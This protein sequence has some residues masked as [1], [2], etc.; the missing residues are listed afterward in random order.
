MFD[1]EKKLYSEIDIIGPHQYRN[2]E[3]SIPISDKSWQQAE[4]SGL[5]NLV[6]DFKGNETMVV[7]KNGHEFINLCSCSYLGLN[8]HPAILQGAIDAVL[9]EK[10]VHPSMSTLR[11]RLTLKD[12]VEEELSSLF[13][14][15]A[16]Q[17]LSASVGSAG[18]LPL[19]ASGHLA[20]GKPHV[21]IFD[22]FCH[23]SMAYMKPVCADEALTLTCPHDDLNFIEDVCKKYPRV[24]YVT[25]GVYSMGGLPSIKGLLELQDKYGLFL[26]FDDSHSMSIK[27]KNG[28][29]YI[30]SQMGEINERT[31][32]VGSLGKGFG[33]GGGVVMIDP[34][35]NA[36]IIRRHAGPMA[37]SQDMIVPVLGLVMAS[38]KI[39][40]S[41]ELGM[42]QEQ[43]L[44][45]I[46]LFDSLVE[47]P[48]KGNKCPI[49][50]I[51]LGEDEDAIR[52][53]KE[54]FELG[55]YS[56]AVYFPIVPKGGAG[57]RIMLRS[58]IARE[59]I[60]RF[61]T[62]LKDIVKKIK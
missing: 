5:I 4:D 14:V 1:N 45:N 13:N 37:W 34:K 53:A 47:T 8:S 42:L 20:G 11:I 60:I 23:F 21:M 10:V 26:F 56:S 58:N 55:F 18:T 7:E 41:P 29:G 62:H 50:L 46:E 19:I 28:E 57:L 35:Q 30:L 27:G 49:R 48:Q 59:D 3:T 54:I 61:C 40:R 22:R 6:V 36:T 17:A 52:A 12:R 51:V 31:V 33:A 43:L 24:A 2:N 16:L 44:Q 15:Q 32:I 25:D 38:I 39:H 9:K